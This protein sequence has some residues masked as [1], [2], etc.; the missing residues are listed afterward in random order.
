MAAELEVAKKLGLMN[1]GERLD[2]LDLDDDPVRHEEVEAKAGIYPLIV[3]EHGK[4]DLTLV[5]QTALIEFVGEACLV[6]AL[7]ESR[8]QSFVNLDGATQDYFADAI[9]IHSAS[10]APLSALRG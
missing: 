10:S 4:H 6:R 8:P 7:K 9:L 5:A 3:I 1:C 2:R